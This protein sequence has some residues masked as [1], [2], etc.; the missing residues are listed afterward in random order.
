MEA[1]TNGPPVINGLSNNYDREI[2]FDSPVAMDTGLYVAPD[3]SL[4]EMRNDLMVRLGFAAQLSYPPPGMTELLNS[5][6]QDA[7]EQLYMRYDMLRTERWWAWQLEAGRRVYDTPIDCTKALDFRKITGAW[8]SDN[9]GRALRTWRK[10]VPIALGVFTNSLTQTAL[11]Y[12]CT[13]AGTAGATE[14]DWPTAAGGTVLDGSVVWTARAPATAVWSKLTRGIDPLL[15]S[16]PDHGLP[17]R[18]EVREFIECWPTPDMPYVLWLRG[19]MGL[20]RLTENTDRT[21][22]DAKAIFLQALATAKEQFGQPAN[23]IWQQLEVYLGR[24]VAGL[25]GDRRYI[26]NG[27]DLPLPNA[28]MPRATF[29]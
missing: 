9:G 23:T 11:E 15:F 18:Y 4:L 10:N 2:C 24:L 16:V 14:P 27:G 5:I 7:Q 20:K 19:H 26:P 6:V 13:T 3:K 21:T 17:Y 28:A 8:L 25:H 1:A 12:E 29:R 22:I